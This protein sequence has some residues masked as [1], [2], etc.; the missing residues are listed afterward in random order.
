MI[1]DQI[2]YEM[3]KENKVFKKMVT[4]KKLREYKR[5]IL[6]KIKLKEKE[7]WG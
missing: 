4:K 5:R 1:N 7:K 6:G 2:Y 3:L